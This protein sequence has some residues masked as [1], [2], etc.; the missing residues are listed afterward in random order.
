MGPMLAPCGEA[1][2]FQKSLAQNG[3]FKG[4]P[5]PFITGGP[6]RGHL[7]IAPKFLSSMGRRGNLDKGP[8]S[9][10]YH[11]PSDGKL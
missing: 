3:Y 1:L 5:P 10:K 7:G 11:G 9:E 6:V 2:S 8:P 4:K